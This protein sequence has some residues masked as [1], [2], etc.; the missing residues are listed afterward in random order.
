MLVYNMSI[1]FWWPW[2]QILLK[3]KVKIKKS[4]YL[5]NKTPT[6]LAKPEQHDGIAKS[7][8]S[9]EKQIQ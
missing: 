4:L 2:M 7:K 8:V 5:E 3:A 1:S 6:T 9:N